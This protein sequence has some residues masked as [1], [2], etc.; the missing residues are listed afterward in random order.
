[1]KK[2]CARKYRK[3][4][5]ILIGIRVAVILCLFAS[6]KWCTTVPKSRHRSATSNVL[7]REYT[8][9]KAIRCHCKSLFPLIKYTQGKPGKELSAFH[10]R[11]FF[12][13]PRLFCS[14]GFSFKF[15]A[16]SWLNSDSTCTLIFLKLAYPK[17]LSKPSIVEFYMQ[18]KSPRD[19]MVLSAKRILIL[20]IICSGKRK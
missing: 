10:R 15:P 2:Y 18:E 3:Y 20:C 14:C 13:L 7:Q 5:N 16:L 11:F 4:G 17:S 6:E 12:L 8:G 19:R 9:T 1:M